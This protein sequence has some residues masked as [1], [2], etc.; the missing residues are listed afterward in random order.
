MTKQELVQAHDSG[1]RVRRDSRARLVAAGYTVLSEKGYEATTVKEVARAAGVSPGL[2]HYYFASKDELLL[3]V[4]KQAAEQYM[5]TMAQLRATMTGERLAAA[6]LQRTRER[7]ARDPARVRLR[8]ELFA[9]G[10]RNAAFLPAVGDLL[11]MGQQGIAQTVRAITEITDERAEALAAVLL[12]GL[13]GLALQQ[14]AQPER[15]LT[16]AYAL[17][18]ALVQRDSAG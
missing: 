11:A 7:V 17:L 6:A 2:F 10:L 13:D 9:L 8:F 3:A 1:S 4:L 12:A 18:L 5:Q 15:D 14:L 16:A